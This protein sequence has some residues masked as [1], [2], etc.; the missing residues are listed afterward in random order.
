MTNRAKKP[1]AGTV[2]NV[3]LEVTQEGTRERKQA[4][5]FNLEEMAKLN[6]QK[7]QE[8]REK[9]AQREKEREKARARSAIKPKP[10]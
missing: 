7:L 1:G 3:F 4:T 5:T 6:A 9:E 2:H 8:V 10:G